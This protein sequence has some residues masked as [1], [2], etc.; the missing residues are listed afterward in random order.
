MS[1]DVDIFL[2]RQKMQGLS[3]HGKLINW[4]RSGLCGCFPTGD[5]FRA[6]GCHRSWKASLSARCVMLLEH[7]NSIPSVAD[8]TAAGILR[9]SPKSSLGHASAIAAV[10]GED[11]GPACWL[12]TIAVKAFQPESCLKPVL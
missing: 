11:L 10:A 12:I 8:T 2:K 7:D 3:G 6:L 5:E 1:K 9:R 4:E